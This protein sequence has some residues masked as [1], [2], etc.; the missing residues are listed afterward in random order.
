MAQIDLNE[1]PNNSNYAK[2]SKQEDIRERPKLQK[3][4]K[5][6]VA[7]TKKSLGKKFQETF[8]GENISNMGDYILK[9]V[10]IPTVKNLI[11][12]TISNGVEMALFGSVRSRKKSGIGKF[13]SYSD[14]YEKNRRDYRGREDSFRERSNMKY[15]DII[16]ESRAEAHE[17]LDNLL[18]YIDKYEAVSIG[19]LYDLVGITSNFTDYKWG[20]DSLGSARIV[21]VRGGYLLDLPKAILLK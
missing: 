5:K 18:E 19:E 4:T 14:Y 1:L 20:W 10:L 9:D 7:K 16:L 3:I 17:V 12:D 6:G 15:D 13:I 2:K 8:L 11:F 21:A